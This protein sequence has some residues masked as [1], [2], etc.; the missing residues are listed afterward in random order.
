[1]VRLPF[2]NGVAC[3]DFIT[4][5]PD[6]KAQPKP[7]HRWTEWLDKIPNPQYDFCQIQKHPSGAGRSARQV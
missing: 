7:I 6:R 4:N 3:A 5:Q 1:M 2:Q